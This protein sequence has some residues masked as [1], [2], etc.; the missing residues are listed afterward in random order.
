MG[1][2]LNDIVSCFCRNDSHD[3]HDSRK[4]QDDKDCKCNKDNNI[5]MWI[6]IIAVFFCCSGKGFLPGN[7]C[8]PCEPKRNNNLWIILVILL[9]CICGKDGLGG[10]G[11]ILG[12][13]SGNLNT[14]IINL[15]REDYSDDY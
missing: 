12:G 10:L 15:D 4:C 2:G 7:S 11:G 5:F 14:N 1:F 13:Q 9:I 8:N 6:L 3:S